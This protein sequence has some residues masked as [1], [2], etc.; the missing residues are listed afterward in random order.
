MGVGTET[1]LLRLPHAPF[2]WILTVSVAIFCFSIIAL[3]IENIT[4]V[5][6]R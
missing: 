3:I 2:Y 1:S 6:K 5:A 4:Q